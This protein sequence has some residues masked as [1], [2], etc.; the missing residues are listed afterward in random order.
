MHKELSVGGSVRDLQPAQGLENVLLHATLAL[1]SEQLQQRRRSRT[2]KKRTTARVGACAAHQLH[3]R[4]YE[5]R[6]LLCSVLFSSA[7][8]AW[9]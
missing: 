5:Q 2:R 3:K 9:G 4:V 7:Q 8:D 1:P 6:R